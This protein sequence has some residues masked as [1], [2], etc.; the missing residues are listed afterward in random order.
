MKWLSI[1]FLL[2]NIA[3]FGW[4]LDKQNLSTNNTQKSELPVIPNSATELTILDELAAKP[5][6]RDATEE[7]ALEDP[8]PSETLST[9]AETIPDASNL[10]LEL[11][12]SQLDII[13]Q[14]TAE[15]VE[16]EKSICISYGPIETDTKA[17]ELTDYFESKN[18]VSSKRRSTVE[19]KLYWVYLSPQS[20]PDDAQAVVNDLRQKGVTD[21]QLIKS[22]RFKNAISLGLFSS[23]ERVDY[24]LNEINAKGYKPIVVPYHKP[25]LNNIFW[26]DAKFDTT[27]DEFEQIISDVPAGFDTVPIA[28]SKIALSTE[29]P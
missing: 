1:L 10:D 15:Q 17:D 21:Y 14:I 18:V 8:S 29:N 7:N 20:N 25:K 12:V 2:G 27:V 3:Y 9:A 26:V 6:L 16:G 5:T 19:N 4:E 23:K 22:G 11:K 13:K 24:R 28:C